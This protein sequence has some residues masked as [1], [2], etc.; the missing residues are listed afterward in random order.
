MSIASGLFWHHRFY[1]EPIP[2][3]GDQ[4]QYTCIAQD[5]L[6]EGKFTECGKESY[7]E[8]LYPLFLAVIFK[9]SNYNPD[10]VRFVQLF[11]YGFIS[12][13]T[14]LLGKKLFNEKVGLGAGIFS[15]VFWVY[16][17]HTGDIL[18]EILLVFLILSTVYFLYLALFEKRNKYFILSG[19]F[20]GL[21]S[22]TNSITQYLIIF[23]MINFIFLLKK[24]LLR[25]ELILKLS[26][27]LVCFL[28]V[29][30]PW[31]ARN[32]IVSKNSGVTMTSRAG[33]MLSFRV[34][35]MDL[36][37]PNIYKYYI[38]HVI[39]YYFAEKI[40]PDLDILAFRN[41]PGLNNE[42]NALI[43]E[44]KSL[45]EIDII[46]TERSKE[47]ILKNP[48]KYLLMSFLDFLA[49]NNPV[50]PQRIFDGNSEPYFTFTD[51]RHS[52]VPEFVKYILIIS[53]RLFWFGLLFFAV[54]GAS[55]NIKKWHI[56]SWLVIF[57][58]YFNGVY[59]AVFAIP[60]Y[61]IQIYPFYIIL[62]FV[63]IL[64]VIKKIKIR[65]KVNI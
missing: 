5:I 37:Y 42:Y 15:S 21:I 41:S 61:A 63:G 25:K 46:L 34:Y 58:I 44:G 50:I 33:H 8:P 3:G 35:N 64:F 38:G 1:F 54:L 7:L 10:A 59:S 26:L 49:F 43:R 53:F 23:V 14:Y 28:V 17:N 52:D 4:R 9:I 60:R 27:L 65:L 32:C 30:A 29:I 12:V 6:N 16:A 18:R 31:F 56:I 13:L 20:L 24:D 45:S 51:G 62:A 11:L 57:V 22:L 48:N 55:V 47:K 2:E 40:F 19:V 36:L 39:G